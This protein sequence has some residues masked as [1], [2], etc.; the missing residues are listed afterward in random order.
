M[1]HLSLI[2][3]D[4]GD[5]NEAEEGEDSARNVDATVPFSREEEGEGKEDGNERPV[6][7]NQNESADTS[8]LI[9]RNVG[10]RTENPTW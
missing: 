7:S 3:A 4:S 8:S 6:H 9:H 10:D 2:S 1:K 5:N